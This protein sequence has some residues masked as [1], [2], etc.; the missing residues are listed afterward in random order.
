MKL[1]KGKIIG[2]ALLFC[3]VASTG[4]AQYKSFKIS[5]KGDTINKIDKKNLKQ[6]KFVLHTDE[7]RGEPGFEEEGIY[8]NDAKEGVWRRYNL[9]GDPI[10]FETYLHG[11]KDGLQQYY[12]PLGELLREENWRGYNPDAP[13]DTI[14]VYGT[15]SNEIVDYKIVKA[16]QYS[17][18]QGMWRYYEPVTGRL[19]KSEEWDRN[20][21]VLPNSPKKEVAGGNSLKGIKKEV[22]KTPEMLEWEKK[23]KGKKNVVRN[24]QT[25][26]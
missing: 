26:L 8:K 2:F 7:L 1:Q 18:K 25:G 22:A 14:A 3:S 20:N 19:L 11:G 15:G 17:V 5:A 21:L 9:Q 12:S 4:Y 24:G 6:G 13:Y 23:N 16:E 10:G